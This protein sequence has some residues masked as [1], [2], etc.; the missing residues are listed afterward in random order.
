MLSDFLV[1]YRTQIVDAA[2]RRVASRRYP[3]VNL[4]ALFR[5]FITAEPRS[6]GSA[7]REMPASFRRARGDS[8]LADLRRRRRL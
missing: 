1:E 7:M 3:G 4:N 5:R 2:R 6:C 8:P